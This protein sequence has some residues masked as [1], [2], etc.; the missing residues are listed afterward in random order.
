MVTKTL[1]EM[2]EEELRA[3]LDRRKLDKS[4]KSDI[5]T[6]KEAIHERIAGSPGVSGGESNIHV[7]ATGKP[8]ARLHETKPTEKISGHEQART[9][10][11][12][13]TKSEGDAEIRRESNIE[14][15]AGL[16]SM[17][18]GDQR[19]DNGEGTRLAPKDLVLN[20]QSDIGHSAGSATR[21]DANLSAIRTL[22]QIEDDH[23]NATPE[24]QATM[25][26]Y[27]GFGDSGMGEAFPSWERGDFKSTPWGRR[28]EELKALTTE[29]EFQ[30]IER[31][32]L[33]AFF[34]TPEVIQH[35]WQGLEKL[36]VDE[37]NNPRILEPSAGSGRFL[38]YQPPAMATKSE[39]IAVELDSLTGRLLKYTYPQTETYI[40]GFEKAPIQKESIDVAISN[41]PFGNYP[42][43]DPEF[44]KDRKK[45]T[46]SIHNYFFAKTLDVLRPGGVL[47]F[48]TSHET[49]DAPTAKPIR[50]A[51]ADRADLISA[52]RLPNSAFPDTKVVTDIIFM[53]KRMPGEQPGDQ[54]WVGTTKQTFDIESRYGD[55]YQG[56]DDVSD[57]FVKHPGMVLGKQDMSEHGMRGGDEYTVTGEGSLPDKLDAAVNKIPSN[58]VT[59]APRREKAKR[60]YSAPIDGVHEGSHVIGDDGS[61]YVQR[62]GALESANLTEAEETK[63]KG[64]LGIR[65]TAKNVVAIQV[66]N[67]NDADLAE[68]QSKLGDQY[69]A[70]VL[71]HGTLT[72]N[73]ELL[74]K[75][76][77]AP[78][79]KALEN[80][81]VY[82]K[83]KKNLTED[84]S[85]LIKQLEGKLAVEEKDIPKLQMPIFKARVI[86]GLGQKTVTNYADAESVVKN[87]VGRLDFD[88]MADKLG[89]SR[90]EVIKGLAEQKIIYKNPVGDWEPADK[91]LSGDVRNKLRQAE[92][93]ATARPR[94]FNGNVEA[95]KEVQPP[96]VSAGQISVRMGAPWI[97]ETDINDFT[98]GLL[99]AREHYG[100]RHRDQGKDEYFKYNV[101]TGQWQ[102]INKPMASE[103]ALKETYGT[104]RINATNIIHRILNGKLIE[105]N[106]KVTD[107]DGKEHSVRNIQET[108]A[109]QEK[110]KA[111][112]EKFQEWIWSD[113]ERTERLV[114]SYNDKFNNIKPR[115]FDGAH[116]ELPG[117]SEKWYRQLHAHQKDAIWRVKQDR[118]A[119]LAH[120]VGFGK[121]AVMVVSG[122]ELKRLGLAN[123]VMYVVPKATHAQFRDQYLDIYPFAKI[124][125][126]GET[127]FTADKRAEFMSRAITGD[128]DAIIVADSQF[129]KMPVRPETEAKFLNEEMDTIRE[130]LQDTEDKKTQK[131]LQKSLERCRVRM[132]GIQ[133][134][135]KEKNDKT[136][137]FEDLGLDQMYVDEADAY[138]NLHFTTM[139]GRIKGLPNSESDRAW[140]MY[141]KTRTL[142]EQPGTGVVF[143]TGT[144]VANTIAEMYT[145][146]RYLQEPMLEERGLKHFDAWAKTFGET[147]ESLEQ[148]PTGDY[149][150]TQRFAKF[151]NAP[152]LSNMWQT[153]ADIRVA[154]EVPEMVKQ[155]PRI[156]DE[157]GRN[158]RIV[159]SA[160]PDQ[161]LID[162][163]AELSKR[164]DELKGKDPRIDNMLKISSDARKAS[165]DM[166]LVKADAPVNPNGKVALACKKIAEIYDY[167][168]KDKGTQLVFLDMGTPKAK[169]KVVETD[170]GGEDGEPD[171]TLEEVKLLT[172]V[173]RNIKAQLIA[174]GVRAEEIAFIHDAKNDKQKQMLFEKVNKGDV[175]V[176][177]GSTGK[178]GTGVNVQERAAALHHLDAPWRPR[179]IEQREGRIIRQGNK[180][181]GPTRDKNGKVI[182]SGQG[183]RVYTY[184]TERSFDAYM[185]QAIE[186]KSKAI[187][188]I[189][190]RSVPPRT[191][192]D[193]DSFTMSASE[194]KAVASGD[195]NVFKAVTLKNSVTKLQML[196]ASHTDSKIRANVQLR[197]LPIQIKSLNDSI[198]KME[199]D[200]ALVPKE[201]AKFQMTVSGIPYKERIDAGE[202]LAKTIKSAKQEEEVANYQGFKVRV[203]DQGPQSGYM[204][205]IQNPE[206]KLDYPLNPIP[207]SDVNAIGLIKRLTNRVDMIPV[208]LAKA[209]QQ[210]EENKRNLKTYKV[211]S[212]SPFDHEQQLTAM[213]GELKRLESKLQGLEVEGTPSD[214][215]VPP[216]D[217]EDTPE[218]IAYHWG[219]RSTEL[220]PEAEIE[221]VKQVVEPVEKEL[222]IKEP[223][224]SE[225]KQEM[226]V[227]EALVEKAPEPIKPVLSK[228]EIKAEIESNP[229][230]TE[231]GKAMS[232]EILEKTYPQEETEEELK[233]RILK[234]QFPKGVP[235]VKKPWE[236][237]P[238]QMTLDEYITPFRNKKGEIRDSVKQGLRG[239]HYN[240]VR[241]ALSEGKP[242]PQGVLRDYP[243]LVTTPFTTKQEIPGGTPITEKTL[244]YTSAVLSQKEAKKI[245]RKAKREAKVTTREGQAVSRH[246]HTVEKVGATPTPAT[247]TELQA[248]EESRSYR[249][250]V[251]DE[252]RS[253][254][255][256][257]GQS[258][259]RTQRWL[260]HPGALDVR[261]I[262]T[263]N[264]SKVSILRNINKRK[265]QRAQRDRELGDGIVIS[266]RKGRQIR[267]LK[268]Y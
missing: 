155:R 60:I 181:Y 159:I 65:D 191:I 242:I 244:G 163:M 150:M 11:N 101:I 186:A 53:R 99:N 130:A 52:I 259:P 165:L 144:P 211:Q 91:Y 171:E 19:R 98:Q 67:G 235:T 84:D 107:G 4:A 193:I 217:D 190:R 43:F 213:E 189:M 100:W 239:N 257:I 230:L 256:T 216:I 89:K 228:E 128:W 61:V 140:D 195:P 173:Y 41:V 252:G 198:S 258:N 8:V 5:M 172:D 111:I 135:L 167:T 169:D 262:D 33:N 218:E 51:L 28:R 62:Q 184:V 156:V 180:L 164:A 166:R 71:A 137:Y 20:R 125:Y 64:M 87:E 151:G 37:L 204:F 133:D 194:A 261:G 96:E 212:E 76:A 92:A 57:Y 254:L 240:N 210:L 12:G 108:I 160:P 215:Y 93:A 83:D 175:R 146:M 134:R 161:A 88:I 50:Q 102:I 118:T 21:F 24:E 86:H 7:G 237:E 157:K 113:P 220:N 120:E 114:L 192:E 131:E 97:P 251:M 78:F 145:N 81:A 104:S 132:L 70:Y 115:T 247:K 226:R 148:T 42:V 22:K 219:A 136:I 260:N 34:T 253:N 94:E 109:A 27:S 82:K 205:V 243:D 143:A 74:G 77:D 236:K 147:T 225:V 263:S 196:R 268:L 10:G 138:K 265:F 141:Q 126:P 201:D 202:A 25:A 36:G 187:K 18:E 2:T 179:D 170:T 222:E 188:A 149:R 199:K 174:D 249:S 124:L 15:S 45:L 227:I 248:K 58:V 154:D 129:R 152:E 185:W 95:L 56:E 35:M 9:K 13:G 139:M 80:N 79:L 245:E 250:R 158:R 221:A 69:K 207:Y 233:S 16:P 73:T 103:F 122:Q 231:T 68:A 183:V 123:K 39:R 1:T 214:N 59:E 255:T 38:G 168:T 264:L 232:K 203:H 110:A 17:A 116:Q 6:S 85:H 229:T 46:R 241:Q 48:I 44:K 246:P 266:R 153:T 32:R 117:T 3:E 223:T 40:M 23:R 105:V 178:L 224:K 119:L 106:D 66:R 238:W 90:D 197:Q 121:T 200:K 112:Q 177:I 208:E 206:T 29:D 142:Q 162:Y 30:S 267:H 47:A 127:D 72:S 31:S 55:N 176:L 75:D 26:K 14:R 54:S 49:L 63:V 234:E 182:D 209:K